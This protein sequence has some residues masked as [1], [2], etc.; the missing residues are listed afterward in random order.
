MYKIGIPILILLYFGA[1]GSVG[2]IVFDL[3]HGRSDQ[4]L[5]DYATLAFAGIANMILL[6]C[7]PLLWRQRRTDSNITAGSRELRVSRLILHGLPINVRIAFLL[8]SSGWVIGLLVPIV[9]GF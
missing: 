2:S 6:P 4:V 8:F 1:G 5:H 7:L 9:F 3:A